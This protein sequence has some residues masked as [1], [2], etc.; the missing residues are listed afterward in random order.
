MRYFDR[1]ASHQNRTYTKSKAKDP[2]DE[3]FTK[4]ENKN[5]LQKVHDAKLTTWSAFHHFCII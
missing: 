5:S 2:E 4:G 3:E 1:K